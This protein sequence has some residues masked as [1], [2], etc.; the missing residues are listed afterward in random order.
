MVEESSYIPFACCVHIRSQHCTSSC[1]VFSDDEEV[2]QS[3]WII[4][5]LQTPLSFG[6]TDDF[7]SVLRDYL[8]RLKAPIATHTVASVGGLDH[9][10]ADPV[11]P[12]A[13]LPLCETREGP[14]GAVFFANVTVH[15]VTLVEHDAILAALVAPVLRLAHALGLVMAC[16]A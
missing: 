6:S 4:L 8:V 13:G 16:S 5:F 9:L 14:V 11:F 10:D 2:I 12:P 15:A 1:Y 3:L 7:S